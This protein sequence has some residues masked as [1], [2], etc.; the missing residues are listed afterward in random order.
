MGPAQALP[1]EQAAQVQPSLKFPNIMGMMF[2]PFAEQGSQTMKNITGG[3][4]GVVTPAPYD[5]GEQYRAATRPSI[6]PEY[7]KM[8]PNASAGGPLDFVSNLFPGGFF[9]VQAANE[10]A[11]IK[12]DYSSRVSVESGM[13][14]GVIPK[15][16]IGVGK[17]GNVVLE[18]TPSNE[19][20]SSG[21]FGLGGLLPSFGTPD[22][23]KAYLTNARSNPVKAEFELFGSGVE[24]SYSAG[25]GALNAIVSG[26]TF[27]LIP[28]TFK[29]TPI[30]IRGSPSQY[31]ENT[32][33]NIS[34]GSPEL[35]RMGL[36]IDA[37]RS[38]LD[39]YNA[40][41]ASE[42]N[43]KVDLFNAMQKQNPT[44][45]RTTITRSIIPG[46]GTPDK[47]YG[48]EWDR[49]VE[50]SGRVSRN[51]LGFTETQYN[52][53]G[54]TIKN[55]P[56]LKGIAD[57]TVYEVGGVISNKPASLAPDVVAGAAF[58]LGGEVIGAGI[59]GIAA[60]TSRVTPA[61]QWIMSPTGQTV[62][63]AGAASFFGTLYGLNVTEG[64]TATP[65]R[66]EQN[67][68]RS[69]L[70]LAA[71]YGGGGGFRQLPEVAMTGIRAIDARMGVPMD[72]ES[73]VLLPNAVKP[74][75]RTIDLSSVDLT[76]MPVKESVPGAV[77]KFDVRNIPTDR[78]YTP[79]Q[80]PAKT[81]Y[82]PFSVES[83]STYRPSATTGRMQMEPLRME[84][85]E[86]NVPQTLTLDVTNLGR[87]IKNTPQNLRG[88]PLS[89]ME[90]ARLQTPESNW[91]NRM[92]GSRSTA[93]ANL[94]TLREN[95]LQK[96]IDVSADSLQDAYEQIFS[97]GL[98]DSVVSEGLA[99]TQARSTM[100]SPIAYHEMITDEHMGPTQ[101][102]YIA[103][104]AK[105]QP[106]ILPSQSNILPLQSPAPTT[107]FGTIPKQPPRSE[108]PRTPSTKPESTKEKYYSPDAPKETLREKYFTPDTTTKEKYYNPDRITELTRGKDTTK[109]T[110]TP[111]DNFR[112]R[113]TPETPKPGEIIFPRFGGLPGGGGG[114]G[115]FRSRKHRKVELFSFEMGQDTPIPTRY[116]LAG[117]TTQYVPGI[118]GIAAN[119]L[120]PSDIAPNRLFDIGSRSTEDRL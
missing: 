113:I 26:V 20:Q 57:R 11:L 62:V 107:K 29:T 15:P 120:S 43:T 99:R 68:E 27:G 6:N 86:T 58:V 96:K 33:T 45:E 32:V 23:Q 35:T 88:R 41:A 28:Q 118:R 66:T 103:T 92:Q 100:V 117:Q 85:L 37:S 91:G 109:N 72:I 55:E 21:P 97:T 79:S 9:G 115:G 44:I 5:A 60:G 13:N 56:G 77:R 19:Y 46:T 54:E 93:K 53:Y 104:N 94:E 48:S 82:E 40:T 101:T 59:A 119:I 7:Q 12:P 51:L 16:F 67:I 22:Q 10:G 105:N 114:G 76:T 75:T 2:S 81:P 31:S 102:P 111:R 110:E 87:N 112:E 95:Q 89:M 98:A 108:Q 71:M 1:A 90:K 84:T 3:G 8:T 4:M 49:F 42:F 83:P 61:A 80:A 116:G 73:G 18:A 38:S 64:F 30:T 24:G 70:P 69:I 63:K 14:Y 34:G 50:G 47:I 74:P 36:E 17:G 78:T 106:Q 65:Q 39:R 25:A 52:T